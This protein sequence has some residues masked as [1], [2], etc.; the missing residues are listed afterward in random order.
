MVSPILKR[1]VKPLGTLQYRKNDKKGEDYIIRNGL[2]KGKATT[3]SLSSQGSPKSNYLSVDSAQAKAN[4][5]HKARL[6]FGVIHG[7]NGYYFRLV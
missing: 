7:S 2:E 1:K 4:T 3:C 5:S 6:E